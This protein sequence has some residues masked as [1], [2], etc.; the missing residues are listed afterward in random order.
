MERETRLYLRTE[1]T[2]TGKNKLMR[3]IEFGSGHR[4][5]IPIEKDGSI[6]WF[7]DSR[8]LKK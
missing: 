1:R 6:K 4:V 7:D 8:L 3:V 5:Q 2:D